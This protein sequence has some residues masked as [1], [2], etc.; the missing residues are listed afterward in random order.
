[1]V[2]PAFT[3]VLG[4]Q[5]TTQGKGKGDVGTITSVFDVWSF[6]RNLGAPGLCRPHRAPLLRKNFDSRGY[7]PA[8]RGGPRHRWDKFLKERIET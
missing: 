1:M 3:P 6:C 4:E 5:M 8:F 2:S 7:T